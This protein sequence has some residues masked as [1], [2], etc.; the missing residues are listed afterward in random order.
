M[1]DDKPLAG[2][3]A[4]VAGATRGGGRGSACMLGEAGAFVVCTGRSTREAG[5]TPGRPETIEETAEMVRAHGGEAVSIRCDHTVDAE[6]EALIARIKAEHG[7][8]DILVNDVWGGDSLVDWSKKFWDQDM[9]AVRVLIE[10]ALYSHWLT[11]RHAAGMMVKAGRGLIVEVGDGETSGWRGNILYDFCKAGAQRL[12]YAMAWDLVGTGVTALLVSPGFLRSEAMLQT[13]GVTEAN[14]RD[15][16][17]RDGGW[18]ESETPFLLGRA[19]AALAAD[20]GVGEKAGGS[21]FAAD[22]AREYG[23]TDVDGRTPDFWGAI[24]A[25]VD[26]EYERTGA[27]TSHPTRWL[28]QARYAHVHRDVAHRALA[29]DLLAKLKLEGLGAG[30]RPV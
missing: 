11:A 20:P 18:A 23:F 26:E 14:W 19:I 2:Q 3:V 6:V 28:A 13:F 17:A 1:A 7:R 30:L 24:Q 12:A 9:A 22:L 8:L 4:L 5:A 21:Y 27:V 16:I 15:G 10:R 29:E 25:R